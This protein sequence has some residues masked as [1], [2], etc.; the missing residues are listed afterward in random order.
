MVH[1]SNVGPFSAKGTGIGFSSSFSRILKTR[2]RMVDVLGAYNGQLVGP[3]EAQ[4]VKKLSKIVS[5][6]GEI[7]DL[8]MLER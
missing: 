2:S 1:V 6:S 8:Q 5:I 7:V 4:Y 3:A